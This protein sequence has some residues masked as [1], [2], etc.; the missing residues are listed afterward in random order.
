VRYHRS[1]QGRIK[2]RTRPGTESRG[3]QRNR[4]WDGLREIF[5]HG[6]KTIYYFAGVMMMM[7]DDGSASTHSNIAH[8]RVAALRGKSH[9]SRRHR[10]PPLYLFVSTLDPITHG[11][12]DIPN[13][14]SLVRHVKAHENRAA[15]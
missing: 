12:S 8:V 10:K 2:K 1:Q 3:A 6:R 14:R 7:T 4:K 5:E 11:Q 15:W 13:N 9:S